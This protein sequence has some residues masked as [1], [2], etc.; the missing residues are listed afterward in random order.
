MFVC[1]GIRNINNFYQVLSYLTYKLSLRCNHTKKYKQFKLQLRNN[2]FKWIM[3]LYLILPFEMA[4]WSVV[5]VNILFVSFL[6]QWFKIPC[7]EI[8]VDLI[9]SP[10]VSY[11]WSWKQLNLIKP[12]MN[13]SWSDEL[14]K[15]S[16]PQMLMI[17]LIDWLKRWDICELIIP[18]TQ[19]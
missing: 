7:I 9:N 5:S 6:L 12:S 8:I 18:A 2:A 10:I 1:V 13:R 15:K 11:I 19:P 3:P 16:S 14:H 17:K 4:W